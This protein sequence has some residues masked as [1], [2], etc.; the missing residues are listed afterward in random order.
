M[1][2]SLSP[3]PTDDFMGWGK[4][5]TKLVHCI[6]ATTCWPGLLWLMLLLHE[7]NR[8]CFME[9][10]YVNELAGSWRAE[11]GCMELM[12]SPPTSTVLRMSVVILNH[13]Q[14]SVHLEP[15]T[16]TCSVTCQPPSPLRWQSSV[17]L[18]QQF[19]HKVPVASWT[20]NTPQRHQIGTFAVTTADKPKELSPLWHGQLRGVNMAP[21]HTHWLLPY[22]QVSAWPRHWLHTRAQRTQSRDPP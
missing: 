8:I 21:Q 17:C 22:R 5:E 10:W 12:W 11:P 20:N 6:A 13:K 3:T 7:R 16:H 1:G 14:L 2:V 19:S 4:N 9:K 18:T 15:P